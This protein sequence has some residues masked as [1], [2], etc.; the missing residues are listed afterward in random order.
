MKENDRKIIIENDFFHNLGHHLVLSFLYFWWPR[1]KKITFS[2]KIFLINQGYIKNSYFLF[3]NFPMF[4]SLLIDWENYLLIKN[5]F[6]IHTSLIDNIH[7]FQNL[8]SINNCWHYIKEVPDEPAIDWKGFWRRNECEGWPLSSS[9]SFS[10]SIMNAC[11][12]PFH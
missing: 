8:F 6:L 7:F 10:L 2:N 11:S 9:N 12:F 3:N 5:I 1:W 4:F